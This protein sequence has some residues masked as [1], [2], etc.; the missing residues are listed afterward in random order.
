MSKARNMASFKRS[1]GTLNSNTYARKASPSFSGTPTGISAT[2]IT[3]GVLPVGVTGG[4]GLT[5]LGT[6]G[7]GT[8]SSGVTGGS[9]LNALSASNLSA[10]TVADARFPSTL[11]VVSG[12]NLTALPAA[13]ITGE[14][15]VGVTGGSGLTGPLQKVGGAMTGAITTNSTFDGVDIAT[16]DAI[17]T[18]TTT[19]AGAALPK[20]GGTMTGTLTAPALLKTYG[21]QYWTTHGSPAGNPWVPYG[22]GYYTTLFYNSCGYAAMVGRMYITLD[23]SQQH[24]GIYDFTLSRYGG[25]VANR[26]TGAMNSYLGLSSVGSSPSSA[27]HTAMRW[28]NTNGASWGNGSARIDVVMWRG[29][30]SCFVSGYANM[31]DNFTS[32]QD[33]AGNFFHRVG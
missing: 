18:S 5:A 10:G 21:A 31:T 4:S 3:T 28:T 22:G 32:S 19:T 20:A 25:G 17:L 30:D 12:A 29:G 11:P 14:L 15:P 8:L 27:N 23:I 7:S 16:R 33:G 9:G 6:I 26:S 24:Q 13:N 1:D 2:H